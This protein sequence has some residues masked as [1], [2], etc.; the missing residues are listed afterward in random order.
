[1]LTIR[2]MAAGS[3]YKYLMSSV[4]RGDGASD[5]S[6]PLTRYYTESGTPPGRFIGGGV[7]G[8]GLEAGG[9]VSDEHL[10]RMLVELVD[11]VTG[12][13]LGR[14]AVRQPVS[15]AERVERRLARL[16]P[17]AR[18]RKREEIMAEER[19]KAA[20]QG[21]AVAGFDLTFSPAK[22][23]SAAWALADEGTKALIYDC[24]MR[25]VEQTLRYAERNFIHSRSGKNGVVQEDIEG[26]VAAAYTHYDTRSG[27]PQLH[28]HVV[29]WNR[30]R[31]VSDGDWRS[32]DS[33]GLFRSVV[34]MS[35]IYDGVLSDMLT[36]E[37]G[38]G[39]KAGASRNGMRKHEITG[40]PGALICEFSQRRRQ[41]DAA[42]DALVA[43][44][45]AAH[46]RLPSAVEKRRIAQQAN[47]QTRA[48]KQHRSLAE[49]S[50]EWRERAATHVGARPEA[51]VT[52]L[53][54]RNDL[55]LLRADDLGDDM[56]AEVAGL[57]VEWQG[58][59]RATF[60]R[61]NLMA[62]VARQLA[63]VRFASSEDRIAVI[64]RATDMTVSSAVQVTPPEL[65]HT[66]QRY[67]RPDGS[68]RLRPAD[69]HLYTTAA[70]LDAEQRLLDLSHRTDGPTVA[71]GTVAAVAEANLPGRDYP[72]S[73][74]QA[75]A[76]EKIATS[77]RRLD[78]LVGPA[79]T[80]KTTTM[81][82]LRAAWEAEHG[83]G[84]VL[85]LAPS[86][87][88]ADVLGTELGID[89]DNTAKWL[90]EHHQQ[91]ARLAELGDLE[92]RIAAHPAG[93]P[94]PSLRE[95]AA[96]LQE[97]IE[98][99]QF[100]PGQLV[101]VDE[102]SLAGTFALDELADA[103]SQAGA[104]LV[105]VGDP[106][107]LSA[108][109]AGGMFRSLV[110]DRDDLPAELNDVRRFRHE[111]ER[112]ASLELRLGRDSALDVYKTHGRVVSG[113]KD[114]MIDQLYTD[115]RADRED[116]KRAVMIAQDAATVA[117]LNRRARADRVAAGAVSEHGLT[118]AGGQTAGVG[119][120]VVTRQNNRRLATGKVGFVKNRDLWTVKACNTDGS[121]VVQ[122]VNGGGS[123]VLPAPYVAEHVEL[124]YATTAH[125]AQGMTVDTSHGLVTP[126]TTREALYV[127]ATRGRDSNH[128]YVVTD[129]DP[130]PDTAH[131]GMTP[132]QTA[133]QVLAGALANE[134]AERSATDTIRT[135]WDAAESIPS[136][137]AE[138]Q[139]IARE[140]QAAR[141]DALIARCG[142]TAEQVEQVRASEAYGPL[143]HTFAYAEA[144]GLD[145][146]AVFPELVAARSLADAGDIASVLHARTDRWVERAGSRRQA[147]TDLIAG[148]IPPAHGVTNPDL[149]RAL[150]ER[151]EALER[152]AMALAEQAVERQPPW[153]RHLGTPPESP[154]AR[155]TWLR[156]VR[157]VAAY[158]ERWGI[159]DLRR[160]VDAPE[161]AGTIEQLG[162]QKRA[163]AAAERAFAISRQVRHDGA[164]KAGVGPEHTVEQKGVEL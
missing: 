121:M 26:V 61:A 108:V 70:L 47:L 37:L 149:A 138:Y 98:R 57:A 15:V 111:W 49:M 112:T 109:D 100:R 65:L 22:S 33:R 107:Q 10:R 62:E 20:K 160:P 72:L 144:R 113:G 151:Q 82:G 134:G 110:R 153:V 64:D 77:R 118:V 73:T 12:E 162:H 7:A 152:R 163:Q 103:A 158:R 2:R 142:L 46:G 88:A 155:A 53:R 157:V 132:P 114:D 19:Q 94:P 164:E 83:A 97:Q 86:A 48:D 87:G 80:G 35:E 59:R 23:V 105:L 146:E 161:R 38:V 126:L 32:L 124:A 106:H 74:D 31:S 25:A 40:V 85:G 150:T 52:S 79:G 115:W 75:L 125:G 131:E 119:D 27:D 60:S 39:W 127:A 133:R 128:V 11:P 129:F 42:E 36:A 116:G 136:V 21:A 34:T 50:A 156:E 51:W 95:R 81:A 117:D 137:A 13:S 99:W 68:S 147:A 16:D 30:A 67:R 90:H 141:W 28:D 122:R 14:Q 63:G 78:V 45:E 139:T 4:A 44:F 54:D 135:A 89:T 140:A 96:K 9:E 56:L 159:T 104:K 145:P 154:A 92:Y 93:P 58:E 29:V 18:D 120:V 3:G 69:Q 5:L 55:P 66:P 130:D 71:V 43:E 6:S 143:V 148:L 41:I 84:S 102:S 17:A 76:V 101:I 8:L 91:T 24:H 1:V 123:V